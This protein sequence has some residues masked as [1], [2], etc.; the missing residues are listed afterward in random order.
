MPGDTPIFWF[1]TTEDGLGSFY[2]LFP[3]SFDP[4]FRTPVNSRLQLFSV[5][6]QQPRVTSLGL[7]KAVRR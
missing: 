6:N 7:G 2:L 3:E 1:V 5:S 4:S